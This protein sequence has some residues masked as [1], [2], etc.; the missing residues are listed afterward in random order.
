MSR[1]EAETRTQLIYPALQA[2][3][4]PP[5]TSPRSVTPA[6]PVK[7]VSVDNR[8]HAFETFIMNITTQ[9]LHQLDADLWASANDLRTNSKLN[10]GE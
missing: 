8:I 10:G 7:L 4:W 5:T 1:N 9:E 6:V 3:G 2:C